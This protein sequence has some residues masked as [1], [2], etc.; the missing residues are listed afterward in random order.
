[1]KTLVTGYIA[2]LKYPEHTPPTESLYVVQVLFNH[3]TEDVI[4][5]LRWSNN[6]WQE[7]TCGEPCWSR[8]HDDDIVIAFAADIQKPNFH[9]KED[10]E[11]RS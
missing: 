7:Y 9:E 8:L 2:W 11:K 6:S 4:R 3:A 5:Q 10:S 1:M